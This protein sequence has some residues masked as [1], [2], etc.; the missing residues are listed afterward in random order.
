MN[1]HWQNGIAKKRIR[2][3][4]EGAR[5][6]QLHAKSRWSR[7][8]TL[9]LLPHALRIQNHLHQILINYKT[10]ESPINVLVKLELKVI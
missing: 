7:A 2:D 6:K 1:T 3:L 10:N 4:T 9:N 8:I 5:K